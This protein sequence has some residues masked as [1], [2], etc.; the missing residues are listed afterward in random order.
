MKTHSAPLFSHV[1]ALY[2]LSL[3]SFNARA[4]DDP[5]AA[6]R[7]YRYG[8]G[9]GVPQAIENAVRAAAGSPAAAEV[10]QHLIAVLESEAAFDAKDIACR[11][12]RAVGTERAV[13]ALAKLLGDAQLNSVARYALEVIPGEGAARALREALKTAAGEALIGVINSLG[14]RQERESVNALAPLLEQPDMAVVAATLTALGQIG[15]ESALNALRAVAVHY[16]PSAADGG[17]DIEIN[18]APEVMAKLPPPTLLN[19]FLR[20][21][22]ELERGGVIEY[23]TQVYSRIYDAP[24]TT[25]A[26][27]VAALRGLTRLDPP[28]AAAAIAALL[29]GND[30]AFR[31]AA[32]GLIGDLPDSAMPGLMPTFNG[33]PPA[34]LAT[35][36]PILSA[37]NQASVVSDFMRWSEHADSGVRVAALSALGDQV[38]TEASVK[39]LLT[40]AA[41]VTGPERDAARSALRRVRGDLA[42]KALASVVAGGEPALRAE[43][44]RVLGPRGAKGATASLLAAAG[45]TDGTIRLAALDA[46][47]ETAGPAEQSAVLGRL[48]AASDERERE[49]AARALVALSRRSTEIEERAGPLV[50]TLPGAGIPARATLL[51]CL[52]QLGGTTALKAVTA[53]A[54][55][56]N[57]EIQTAAVAALSAWPD[58]AAL[59]PL[60]TIAKAT[61]NPTLRTVA[62]RGYLQLIGQA[63]RSPKELLADYREALSLATRADERR[64]VLAG[65]ANVP[66]AGALELARGFLADAEL[67][68]EAGLATAKIARSVA[69]VLPGPAREAAGAVLAAGVTD[70]IKAQARDVIAYLERGEGYILGWQLAGPF[71]KAGATD[72][73]LFEVAF[74]PEQGGAARWRAVQAENG[75]VPLDQLVGGDNC[76]AYL[77]ATIKSAQAQRVRFELGSDDGAKVWLNGQV[78]QASNVNRGYSPGEDKFEGQLREGANALLVKVTQG[79][80]GWTVG[81]RVRASDGTKPDGVDIAAE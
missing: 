8:Q 45:D 51:D 26:C 68:N 21:A 29:R 50:A 43:A 52:A 74:P 25:P 35:M 6:L 3:A 1:L 80:G 37:R 77:R 62:L 71:A 15:T 48:L 49:A 40:V 76:V 46:L 2:L 12:L 5:F 69:G 13:P 53:S 54:N 57:A 31:R 19:A 38:G 30:E 55:D 78:I 72:H 18:L 58:T 24:M 7:T 64:L 75:I 73:E 20:C 4:A 44:I 10:E 11:Q 16:D 61:P 9:A 67:K 56:M 47:A 70:P 28:Q 41:S 27:R 63:E 23:A 17:L 39:R 65:L 42:A 66:E 22:N 32:T 36:M 59:E 33:L 14:A 79:G 60:R 34:Q 81:V